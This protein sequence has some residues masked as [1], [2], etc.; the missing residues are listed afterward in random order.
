MKKKKRDQKNKKGLELDMLGWWI[1][2]IIILIIIVL[3]IIML[4][5]KS[6]GALNFIKDLF[7]FKSTG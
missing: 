7:K 6:F 1:I 4:K 5:G 2:A 3:A